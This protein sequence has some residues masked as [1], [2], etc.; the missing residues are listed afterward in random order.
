MAAVTSC[1]NLLYNSKRMNK[2]S[3]IIVV[4][5]YIIY[6][7]LPSWEG[8]GFNTEMVGGSIFE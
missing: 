6:D 8:W 5:L 2:V 1:D 4:F 3:K 7:G